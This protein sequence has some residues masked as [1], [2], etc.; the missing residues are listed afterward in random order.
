MLIKETL[1]VD[2]A[3]KAEMFGCRPP[4]G[5]A[6]LPSNFDVAKDR[7]SFY[8]AAEASTVRKLWLENG[9]A[10]DIVIPDDQ[11]LPSSVNKA[12]DWAGPT[13]FVGYAL[14]SQNPHLI[15]LAIGV[16]ATYTTELFRGDR[17]PRN[18]KLSIIVEH[19][20]QDG[21]VKH[22]KLDYEGPPSGISRLPSMI[23]SANDVEP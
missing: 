19:R 9:I 23:K 21:E 1:Y 3:K 22:I 4:N 2:V 8:E 20:T 11:D 12:V 7:S 5:L 14:L 16:I 15:D 10:E 18:A 17:S 6:I 13:I